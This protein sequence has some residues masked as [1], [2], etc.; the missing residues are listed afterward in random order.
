MPTPNLTAI[1]S[2]TPGILASQQLASGD[3]TIYTVPANKAV[4]LLKLVLVNTSASAVVVSVS[5]VP[6]GGTLD[7]THRVVSG[8]SL[9]ANDST[10][11]TEVE[12]VMAGAGDF[13]SVNAATGAAVD[14]MLSGLVMA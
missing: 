6:S 11:I 3:V 13:L 7:G 4:K 14:V 12:G 5:V 2:V 9:A 10:I 8:Y 1:T